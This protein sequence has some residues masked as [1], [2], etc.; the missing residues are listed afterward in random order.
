MHLDEPMSRHLPQAGA[1]GRATL[2]HQLAH[3]A[4]VREYLP[5]DHVCD[6]FWFGLKALL[7]QAGRGS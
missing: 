6:P 1:A 2:R 7:R 5:Q 4:G 3:T